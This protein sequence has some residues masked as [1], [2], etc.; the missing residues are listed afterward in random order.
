MVA[1]ARRIGYK[2]WKET[3]AGRGRG[4]EKGEAACG[5]RERKSLLF[6]LPLCAYDNNI[7]G[8][9]TRKRVAVR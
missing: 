2:D 3:G 1:R 6:S 4:G 7:I 5:G 9:E 8:L